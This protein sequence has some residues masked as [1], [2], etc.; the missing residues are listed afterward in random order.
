M[1]RLIIIFLIALLAASCVKKHEC[2]DY[3]PGEKEVVWDDYNSV[4]QVNDNFGHLMGDKYILSF[5]D[6]I[7]KALKGRD[8]VYRVGGDEFLYISTESTEDE[9]WNK[10]K[11]IRRLEKIFARD[12]KIPFSIDASFG[13][14]SSDEVE[15][16]DPE[17]VYILAD[18][19]MYQMKKNLKKERA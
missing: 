2:A 14:A 3:A 6:I 7:G 8:D 19:R 15:G 5:A 11:F 13:I 10:V 17:D 9:L 1:R 18:K 16:G 4:K 12:E